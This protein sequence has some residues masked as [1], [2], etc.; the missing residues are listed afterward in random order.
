MGSHGAKLRCYGCTVTIPS[1]ALEEDTEIS[2]KIISTDLHVPELVVSPVLK[3]EP[4][5]LHFKY[6]V[7]VNLPVVVFPCPTIL[8]V[9]WPELTLMCCENGTWS[10]RQSAKFTSGGSRF[11]CNHF[12]AYCMVADKKNKKKWMKRLACLLYKGVPDETQIKLT[13]SICDDLEGVIKVNISLRLI[14]VVRQ[15]F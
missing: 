12:S 10:K 8:E 9:E 5:N 1:G 11:E 4:S 7:T 6:P 3:L 14:L 2:L 15:K 13:V